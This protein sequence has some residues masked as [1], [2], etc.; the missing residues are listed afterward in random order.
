M[1]III[2][3]GNKNLPSIPTRVW[4]VFVDHCP[5]NQKRN[6]AQ[7]I[8]WESE[9][10]IYFTDK[11]WMKA[12]IYNTCYTKCFNFSESAQKDTP[13]IKHHPIHNSQIFQRNIQ[14]LREKLW[15]G[16]HRHLHIFWYFLS[17]YHFWTAIAKL[18]ARITGVL[19]RLTVNQVL[20]S[21]N[22]ALYPAS[23]RTVVTLCSALN[24]TMEI[25][26]NYSPYCG[27]SVAGGWGNTRLSATSG[28]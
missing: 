8:Q 24:N 1:H 13:E 19:N 21:I 28:L 5:T 17:I 11:Q 7:Q 2:S 26:V 15:A 25:K 14:Y 16:R 6:N 3:T 9:L 18:R 23:S 22:L 27:R 12:F 4:V 20:L 10:N